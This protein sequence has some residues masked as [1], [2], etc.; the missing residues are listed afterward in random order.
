MGDEGQGAPS[1]ITEFEFDTGRIEEALKGRPLRVTRKTAGGEVFDIVLNTWEIRQLY[2]EGQ[3]TDCFSSVAVPSNSSSATTVTFPFLAG[4]VRE[5]LEKG[6]GTPAQIHSALEYDCWGNEIRVA[7]YGRVEDV[8][9]S[10]DFGDSLLD[11]S[12]W[13]DERITTRRFSAEFE[14]GQDAWILDRLVEEEIADEAGNV[15]ALKRVFFDDET[16][17]TS[18]FGSID[19]GNPTMAL[20]WFDPSDPEGFV[21]SERTGYDSYGNPIALFDP[22]AQLDGSGVPVDSGNGHFREIEY[23]PLFQTF[24][25]KETVHTGN[26]D[27]VSDDPTLTIEARYLHGLGAVVSATNFDGHLARFGYD[28][29]GRLTTSV[30]PGDSDSFPTQEASYVV[31]AQIEGVGTTNW[32][33]VRQ[34]ETPGTAGTLDSRVFFDGFGRKIM[35]RA[36]GSSPDTVVVSGVVQFNRRGGIWRKYL[37][38]VEAGRLDFELP[39]TA[40]AFREHGYDPVGREVLVRQPKEPDA[41]TGHF[42]Q[43]VY[44]PLTV[45]MRDE[46]QTDLTNSDGDPPSPHFGNYLEVVF[47]GLSEGGAPGRLR[48]VTEFVQLA[49]AGNPSESESAWVTHYQYDTLGNFTGYTDSQG[50]Q[51][52]IEYDGLRRQTRMEDPDRGPYA[53]SYDAADNITC[54]QDAKLQLNL[55]TY[56]GVNRISAEYYS[57]SGAGMANENNGCEQIS[58]LAGAA[59]PSVEYHYDF[60]REDLL[61]DAPG[62]NPARIADVIMGRLQPAPGFDLNLDED[63]DIRDLVL[64]AESA[65]QGSQRRLRARNTSG[66]LVW[67]RDGAGEEHYSYDPRQRREWVARTFD[68]T[69]SGPSTFLTSFS[70]PGLC[71]R[72]ESE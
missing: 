20:E 21:H 52:Q 56:D 67:V 15:A 58:S 26:P 44:R 13:D 63:V 64:A 24:P 42:A 10:G 50:N 37:P 62:V 43:R 23:D 55:F 36:E 18:S 6:E 5:I 8:D 28:T 38:Y 4:T 33:E 9:N 14:S 22:L 12:V 48:K 27:S 7:E 19:R 59:L 31:R 32:V 70:Y 51:K 34:R 17:S 68:N 39:S 3:T 45:E 66:S 53:M 71:K 60:A 54:T 25:V 11:L 72:S 57:S 65:S 61:I 29:F 16:F 69:G 2:T 35:M 49:D 40:G 41:Q 46:S 1:L 47:D 30:Q